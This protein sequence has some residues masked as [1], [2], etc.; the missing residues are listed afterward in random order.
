ML[1]QHIQNDE[2]AK[3]YELHATIALEAGDLNEFNQCQTQL[4]ILHAR[5]LGIERRTEFTACRL[6]YFI[7]VD[8]KLEMMEAMVRY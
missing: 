1:V 7:V 6:L 3:A 4:K 2:T 8:S 5:G